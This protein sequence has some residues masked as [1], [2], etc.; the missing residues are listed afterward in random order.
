MVL[1]QYKNINIEEFKRKK[2]LNLLPVSVNSAF[3]CNVFF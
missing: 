3:D 1:I 2:I